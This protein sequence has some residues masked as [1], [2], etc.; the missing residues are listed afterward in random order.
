ME[1]R[2]TNAVRLETDRIEIGA[3]VGDWIYRFSDGGVRHLK[4]PED[5]DLLRRAALAL[6]SRRFRWCERDAAEL[7]SSR[8]P[9]SCTGEVGR[10]RGAAAT[11]SG[12]ETRL[13]QSVC[14]VIR[15]ARR[16]RLLSP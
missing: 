15:G 10:E 9:A 12:G 6:R 8:P 16:S 7:C 3:R 13:R 1:L 14:Q 5:G 2:V 11:G 4:L